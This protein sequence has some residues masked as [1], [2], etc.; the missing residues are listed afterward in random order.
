MVVLL[1]RE[2]LIVNYP[3]PNPLPPSSNNNS[4]PQN[5]SPSS[6]LNS[7]H[8]APSSLLLDYHCPCCNCNLKSGEICTYTKYTYYHSEEGEIT[9]PLRNPSTHYGI[10]HSLALGP[11]STSLPSQQVSVSPPGFIQVPASILPAYHGRDSNH[12]PIPEGQLQPCEFD[13]T[14]Q[15]CSCRSRRQCP[16]MSYP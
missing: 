4:S 8:H 9:I 12:L 5:P 11:S 2:Q 10:H 6:S 1:Y 16:Q 15:Q 13:Q 3:S 7:Y 14:Q